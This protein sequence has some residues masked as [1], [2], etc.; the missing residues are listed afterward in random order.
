MKHKLSRVDLSGPITAL[1]LRLT[2]DG[3]TG[4]I[5]RI[6]PIFAGELYCSF[7]DL[8]L[9]HEPMELHLGWT[10]PDTNPGRLD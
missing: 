2:T 10:S 8:G 5:I 9:L 6:E 1:A 7:S 4:R 3:T